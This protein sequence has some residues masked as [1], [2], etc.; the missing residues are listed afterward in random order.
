MYY[1]QGLALAETGRPLFEGKFEAWTHGPV[2]PDVRSFIDAHGEAWRE[3]LARR[4]LQL[5]DWSVGLLKDVWQVF[6]R[7]TP[8]ELSE[9]THSE[10]PWRKA[11]DGAGWDQ[12]SR[13]LIDEISLHDF[14][15]DVIET[16]ED[17]MADLKIS[18]EPDAPSW[19]K[20]YELGVNLKR[21]A[22]HPMFDDRLSRGLRKRMGY[23]EFPED[24]SNVDFGEYGLGLD[25]IRALVN[26]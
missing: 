22:G 12:P 20:P 25:E 23:G 26:H 9:A 1:A 24:W 2:E 17:L 5:D 13:P 8:S 3:E 16:G 6:G 11:R 18:P 10:M 4:T 21:L 15:A 19:R 7:W 14:F